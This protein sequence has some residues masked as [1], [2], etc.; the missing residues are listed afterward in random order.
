M[1]WTFYRDVF[2]DWHWEHTEEAQFVAESAYGFETRSE[3]IQDARQRG[4]ASDLRMAAAA[5]TAGHA[6]T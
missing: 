2:G 6:Y 5:E 4:Y 3:C 1:N